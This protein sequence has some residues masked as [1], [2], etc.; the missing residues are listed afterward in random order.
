MSTA[1]E[2]AESAA[3]EL[4]FIPARGLDGF[5]VGHQVA[6]KRFWPPKPTLAKLG[7]H[8]RVKGEEP[9]LVM[10]GEAYPRHH[11]IGKTIWFCDDGG[12]SNRSIVP[13]FVWE[14]EE[15]DRDE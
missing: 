14:V 12:T 11:I 15:V 2:R 13:V 8:W 4:W 10:P 7:P 6:E 1:R 5:K 9:V 3:G